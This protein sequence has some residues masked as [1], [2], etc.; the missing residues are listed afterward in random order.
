[1]KEYYA[2]IEALG[3]A[4]AAPDVKSGLWKTY[5]ALV[6][7]CP[8]TPENLADDGWTVPKRGDSLG[9]ENPNRSAA[10]LMDS[11]GRGALRQLSVAA[12]PNSLTI[13]NP[14]F[15]TPILTR[16]QVEAATDSG[17]QI[18][19]PALWA[20]GCLRDVNV[21]RVRVND[22]F[23][24]DI[25]LD[26]AS[27]N[28]GAAGKIQAA[29]REGLNIALAQIKFLE[30]RHEKG[31]ADP[32]PYRLSFKLANVEKEDSTARFAEKPGVPGFKGE[33]D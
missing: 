28:E 23:P 30:E 22:R 33:G 8:Q 19:L 14:D 6:K 11:R 25:P 12:L 27:E 1:M 4:A 31:T 24:S 10:N 26:I 21:L 29:V 2:A 18:K 20:E 9:F 13:F 3:S 7:G 16:N 15:V 5:S 32:G 17:T